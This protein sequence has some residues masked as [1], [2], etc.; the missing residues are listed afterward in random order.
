MHIAKALM[1]VLVA[2][3]A[4]PALGQ[5]FLGEWTATAHTLGGDVSETLSVVKTAKGYEIKAQL[6]PSK[7]GLPR[8]SGASGSLRSVR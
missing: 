2:G 6:V 4:A 8:T 3:F 5:S 1:L 7:P